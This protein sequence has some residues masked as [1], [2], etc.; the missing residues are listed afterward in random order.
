MHCAPSLSAFRRF[1]DAMH[2]LFATPLPPAARWQRV[3]ALL[4]ILLEDRDLQLR[5]ADWPDTRAADGKHTNHLF[6]QDARYGFVVNALVKWPGATTPIHDHAHT[7]TAYSVL[8]GSERVVHY[9]LERDVPVGAIA[10]F[11]E[12]GE[13][14][15]QP[16]FVDVV[17]PHA[18][19]AEFAGAR[20]V[21]LIVRSE[22]IGTFNHRMWK[23]ST[24]EHF[25]S[26]GPTN[27]ARAL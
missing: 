9:A 20:T 5:A 26:P 24:R 10:S 8:T 4:P 25:L 1:V 3:G 11:R 2:D 6:Y 7:W 13:Y 15:V 14:V 19:H 12:T 23:S 17:P 22:R 16:G 21:A 18:P 27:Y